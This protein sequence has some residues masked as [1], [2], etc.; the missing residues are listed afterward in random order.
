MSKNSNSS[1]AD[2]V[3]RL[4][5]LVMLQMKR[6]VIRN[7]LYYHTESHLITVQK[8]SQLIFSVVRP[9]LPIDIEAIH[10]MALLLDVCAVAHDLVQIFTPNQPHTSRQRELGV[11]E[12]ATIKQLF[13]YI[14]SINYEI[15]KE[16]LGSEGVFTSL[17]LAIIEEAIIGT[18]CNYDHGDGAIYQPLLYRQNSPISVVSYILA[19]ADIG[20][21]GIEGTAAYN[22]EGSLLFL[23]ENPDVISI[24]QNENMGN[25]HKENPQLYENI[26]QR[27]LARARFQVNF[28]KS[29]LNRLPRELSVL[30]TEAIPVLTKD[31]FKHLNQENIEKIVAS[32]PTNPDTSLESL[33]K[34]FE[35]ETLIR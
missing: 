2:S 29:R 9:Y 22:R 12:R 28:A 7:K 3:D 10:R 13:S 33:I 27:L 26:R 32:T 11:S 21:L 19:L 5:N 16:S 35:L 1:F 34:F 15:L 18:I 31:V 14:E 17:D 8:N 23:E 25:L 24:I 20:S 30:P 4:N 6:E